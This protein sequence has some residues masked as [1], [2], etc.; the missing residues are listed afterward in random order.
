M[1]ESAARASPGNRTPL[2]HLGNL[3]H[4]NGVAIPAQSKKSSSHTIVILAIQEPG[5]HI[6]AIQAKIVLNKAHNI[7][8]AI[9]KCL[10][11]CEATKALHIVVILSVDLC[12]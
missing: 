10:T 4:P 11:V 2:L 9:Y 1:S 12:C 7:P 3:N 6:S 5:K 8:R